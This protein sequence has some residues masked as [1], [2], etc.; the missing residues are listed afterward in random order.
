[1]QT[2]TFVVDLAVVF[3]GEFGKRFVC[4][5]AYPYLCPTFGACGID[6]CDYCKKYDFSSKISA[7]I[8]LP[9]P[10]AMGMYVEE[11]RNY[12]D[13]FSS[14]IIIAIN[15]HPDVLIDLPNIAEF[16]ALIVPACNQRWCMPGL[17]KQLG[18]ICEEIGIEFESPKP[19]CSLSGN[20]KIL[21]KFCEEFSIGRPEFE[22]EVKDGAIYSVEVVR[23]DPCGSAYFVA[24]RMRGYVIDDVREFW[25]EIH[26]HQCAYPCMAS[27]ERDVELGEAPFHL[28]GYIMVYN[29]SR[30][31]GIDA[32]NFVP[33]H[34]RSIVCQD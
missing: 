16:K 5:L 2:S 10:A 25:K 24:K 33:E 18:E 14:D 17:R 21:S 23:S 34:F 29:F 27:M 13:E 12:V 7:V 26:Q 15:V 30:A 22:V 31:A 20:G 32:I 28:A 11:P 8:E 1:M 4:N 19:F 6:G 3:S 9:E